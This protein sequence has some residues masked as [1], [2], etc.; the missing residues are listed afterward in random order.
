MEYTKP[1]T[2]NMKEKANKLY[3]YL[4]D[5]GRYATKEEI[6]AVLGIGNERSV[7]DVISLLATK[8]PIIS[9]SGGKGYRLAVSADDLPEVERTWAELSSRAEELER[10]MQP[11]I[12]FREK[13]LRY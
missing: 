1:P 13:C 4:K 10:R 9:H 11:L 7:R 8:K 3:K 5:I 2:D 12:A 6:G